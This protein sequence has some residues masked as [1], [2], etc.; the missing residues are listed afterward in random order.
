MSCVDDVG[1]DAPST[2]RDG[3]PSIGVA[4]PHPTLPLK[5]EGFFRG[6]MAGIES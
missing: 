6:A 2:G 5:G 4:H 3:V 1:N